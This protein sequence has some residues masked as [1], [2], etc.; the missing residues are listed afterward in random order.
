MDITGKIE[1]GMSREEK[2]QI[3]EEHLAL[4]VG[5]GSVRVLATPWM[6]AFMERASHG[7]LAEN[8]AADYSS[9]GVSIDVKH[10]APT[11]MGSTVR[12]YTEIVDVQ[13]YQ[14][15]F[16]INAWDEHEQIGKGEHRRVIINL[17]RFLNR[18]TAK[19]KQG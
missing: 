11:P 12:I 18:V 4:H 3:G 16:R 5:S 19:I 17:E 7:L 6:I 14:V 10:I 2:F 13:G 15:L 8:L 1:V 9:V